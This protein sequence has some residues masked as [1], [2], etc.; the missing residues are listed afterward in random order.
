MVIYYHMRLL[1]HFKGVKTLNI[2]YFLHRF[3]GKMTNK[4][5]GNLESF[6]SHI[7]HCGLIRLLIVKELMKRRRTWGYF[8]EKLGYHPITPVLVK[9]REAPSSEGRNASSMPMKKRKREDS[10]EGTIVVA[11]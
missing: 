6:S 11:T 8:L 5:K 2:P 9:E 10:K 1:M 3:L 7:F 4:I